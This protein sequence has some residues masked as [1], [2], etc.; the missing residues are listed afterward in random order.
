MNFT[1]QE[2]L[3]GSTR[4]RSFEAARQYAGA[5]GWLVR[6]SI[7][8]GPSRWPGRK[9]S[10]P[11]AMSFILTMGGRGAAVWLG[12]GRVFKARKK[13]RSCGARYGWGA[14]NSRVICSL[15][16]AKSGTVGPRG[17]ARPDD[18]PSAP[19]LA[20]RG[21][22]WAGW[23]DFLG[24]GNLRGRDRIMRPFSEARTFAQSL[25]LVNS[26]DWE[27]WASTEVRP[28]DIPFDPSAV[29]RGKGWAGWRDFLNSEEARPT[30][31]DF[32]PFE[33]ARAYAR[34]LG[35]RTENRVGNLGEV[36]RQAGRCAGRTRLPSTVIRDGL[37]LG[38]LACGTNSR[39]GEGWRR[40]P[41]LARE[42]ARGLALSS[43]KEW[44]EWAQDREATI[45]HTRQPRRRLSR[46]GLGRLGGLPR[47]ARQCETWQAGP[48]FLRGSEGYRSRPRIDVVHGM[49]GVAR[50]L[51]LG[52][53][54][55]AG[56]NPNL[57]YRG[58]GWAGWGDLLGHREYPIERLRRL[59]H[60][61]KRLGTMYDSLAFKISWNIA[62]GLADRPKDIPA[63][64]P[65]KS[66]ARSG[67]SGWADWLGTVNLWNGT[68]HP[69]P[70]ADPCA[71]SCRDSPCPKC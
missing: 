18:I 43:S 62:T 67:W 16:T 70:P 49:D 33:E 23:G 13:N 71:R 35:L 9:T 57:A 59:A 52:P 34:Q 4:W 11:T 1:P 65:Q 58:Q 31:W 29:Y 28:S 26:V 66:F 32:R 17:V 7:P 60:R 25:G 22:G 45:R 39:R 68:A 51:E 21:Q 5:S 56:S 46:P 27:K 24:T 48:L 61:L 47:P 8:N 20:Y 12:N 44:A 53:P 30:S 37:A 55:S 41:G 42:F 69:R 10:L 2:K 36:A 64:A 63:R 50:P 40:I 19:D 54:A 15:S 6:N 38:R 3:P 14:H